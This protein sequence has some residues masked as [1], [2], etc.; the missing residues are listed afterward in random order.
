MRDHNLRWLAQRLVDYTIAFSQADQ[1]CQLVGI[2]IGLQV[3]V[4]ADGAKADRR[5]FAD[6]QRAA[7]VEVA[8]RRYRAAAQFNADG[9]GDRAERHPGAGSQRLQQHVARTGGQP[10]TTGGRVEAGRDQRLARLH[11][12]G[13]ALADSPLGAQRHQSCFGFFA[14]SGLEWG[15]QGAELV[16]VHGRVAVG[17][18]KSWHVNKRRGS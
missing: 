5:F 7:K 16:C 2:G 3:K 18:H 14:V 8:F 15:L 17:E 1:R 6:A 11:P 12:A 4:K 13:D 10:I 9:R